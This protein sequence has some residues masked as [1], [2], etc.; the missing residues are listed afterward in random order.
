[1]TH[2]DDRAT[3]SIFGDA[4]TATLVEPGN[5]RFTFAFQSFGERNEAIITRN[6]AM[7]RSAPR[8]EERDGFLYLDGGAVMDFTLEEVPVAIRA[9]LAACGETAR[10]VS[11]FAC[12]QA[13][14]LILRSLADALGVSRERVPFTAGEIGN[15]SSASIPL[16]LTAMQ[17]SADL[18]RVLC[19][20]FGVGL[21]IGLALGD[22]SRTEFLGVEE[23]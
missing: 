21:A 9:M 7:R 13:N 22:F 23:I 17:D 16:V 12:H 10:N 11:L 18:S 5:G 14:R 1:M 15:E 2:P 4:G 3:R 20:G 19:A 8:V 6:R